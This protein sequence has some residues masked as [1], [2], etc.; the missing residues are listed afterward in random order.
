MV[1]LIGLKHFVN[2]IFYLLQQQT[3]LINLFMMCLFL[4]ELAIFLSEQ[5]YNYKHP[6]SVLE[7]RL[8]IR[9]A[10]LQ[11]TDLV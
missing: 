6:L 9:Q 7:S 11:D 5:I 2:P 10:G 8:K 4:F 3:A 1:G